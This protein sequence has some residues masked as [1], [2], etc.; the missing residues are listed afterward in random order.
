MFPLVH[1]LRGCIAIAASLDG[2][3]WSV[4][5][6][7]LRCEAYGERSA[8]QPAQGV[9]R[10]LDGNSVF[11]YIHENVPGVT[12]SVFM[13]KLVKKIPYLRQPP[14]QL[15]RYTIPSDVLR[16]WTQARLKELAASAA[17]S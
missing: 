9:V 17:S 11:V 13:P 5:T 1:R 16:E 6:P 8:H 10:S 7:L 14:S 12:M 15:A 3:H 4:A 2:I